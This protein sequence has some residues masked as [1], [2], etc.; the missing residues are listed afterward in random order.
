[1]IKAC[2]MLAKPP[3][4][5]CSENIDRRDALIHVNLRSLELL[6]LQSFNSSDMPPVPLTDLPLPKLMKH[7]N[8]AGIDELKERL[9][10]CTSTEYANKLE[11]NFRAAAIA[12]MAYGSHNDGNASLSGD[13]HDLYSIVRGR[14]TGYECTEVEG[15]VDLTKNVLFD[16]VRVSSIFHKPQRSPESHRPPPLIV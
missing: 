10:I 15:V 12:F 16:V 9:W 1:M 6:D 14:V 13:V 2:E 5:L 8:S 4:R 11:G 3:L 7:F